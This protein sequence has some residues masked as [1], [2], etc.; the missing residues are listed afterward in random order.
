MTIVIETDNRSRVVLPGHANQR[1]VV[2]EHEDG[3]ILLQPAVVVTE[4]QFEYD[5]NPELRELLARAAKSPTA[6]LSYRRRAR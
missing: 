3:S 1:F 4:A 6:K 5:S 2:Q